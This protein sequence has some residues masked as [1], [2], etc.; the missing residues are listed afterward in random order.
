MTKTEMLKAI[1]MLTKEVEAM[2]SKE[3]KTTKASKTV[4]K[5][6]VKPAS[7]STFHWPPPRECSY[8]YKLDGKVIPNGKVGLNAVVKH[9]LG[10]EWIPS[11][12]TYGYY[13]LPKECKHS[14]D[15][16]TTHV[17]SGHKISA[18]RHSA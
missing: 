13:P 7:T 15:G 18:E 5:P 2:N 9:L 1:A 4:K 8:V 3:T 14:V 10:K 6:G 12:E 16:K 11:Y 17:I